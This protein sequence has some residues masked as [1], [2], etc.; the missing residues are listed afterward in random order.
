MGVKE[1]IYIASKNIDEEC[2]KYISCIRCR[3]NDNNVC[4]KA[5]ELTMKFKI[6]D[7]KREENK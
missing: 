3:Y 6:Q 2:K 7:M 1:L 5:H 4:L